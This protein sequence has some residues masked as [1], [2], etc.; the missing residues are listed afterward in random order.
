MAIPLG[1]SPNLTLKVFNIQ[2]TRR[3]HCNLFSMKTDLNAVGGWMN[4]NW[5]I[6]ATKS[7]SNAIQLAI[8]SHSV[9]VGLIKIFQFG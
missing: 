3:V 9:N 8:G 2:S 4:L 6:W 7:I 5:N 1:N